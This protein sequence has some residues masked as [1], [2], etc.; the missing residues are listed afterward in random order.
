[1]ANQVVTVASTTAANLTFTSNTPGNVGAVLDNVLITSA[2]TTQ[3]VP[4]PS[5]AIL[6]GPA[7]VG[8]ATL[9]GRLAAAGRQGR[10]TA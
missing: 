7:L 8:L 5:G 10:S 9:G 6:S 2:G 4:E 1:M 3:A